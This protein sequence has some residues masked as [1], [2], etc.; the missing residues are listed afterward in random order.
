MG[1][2][3]V[4]CPRDDSRQAGDRPFYYMVQEGVRDL[5]PER[6]E[7]RFAQKVPDTFLNLVEH[8]PV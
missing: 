4:S 6:P 1:K 5:L 7:R 2:W 8:L 3:S